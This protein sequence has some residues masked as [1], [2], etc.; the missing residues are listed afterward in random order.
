MNKLIYQGI[1][2][3]TRKEK[4]SDQEIEKLIEIFTKAVEKFAD[5]EMTQTSE[6]IFLNMIDF[7]GAEEAGVENFDLILEVE[8]IKDGRKFVG[9][10][11]DGCKNFKVIGNLYLKT[12]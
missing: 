4:C 8:K 11:C 7:E 5:K 1:I 9:K 2:E 12:S 6:E 3:D 10:F